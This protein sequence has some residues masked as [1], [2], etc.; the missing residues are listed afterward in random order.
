MGQSQE[1]TDAVIVETPIEIRIKQQR[2]T[3]LIQQRLA[4]TM[5][6]PQHEEDLIRGFLFTEG[7]IKGLDELLEINQLD[8]GL[9]EAALSPNADFDLKQLDRNFFVNSSCGI[10]G[11]ASKENIETEGPFLPWASNAFFSTSILLNLNEKLQSTQSLFDQTGAVHAAALIDGQGEIRFLR[12]DVGRH[13]AVD[14]VVGAALLESPFPLHDVMLW[15]SGRVS[16][17]LVQKGAM[18]GI[19]LLGAVGAP[20]SLAIETAEDVGMSLIGFLKSDGFNIYAGK[21]RIVE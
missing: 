17:E 7:I 10:C 14:K 9:F 16:F 20:S 15:V 3:E 13:N 21:D 5:C 18:A 2:S 12:E 6:T 8:A 1:T 4:V 11:K 19:P